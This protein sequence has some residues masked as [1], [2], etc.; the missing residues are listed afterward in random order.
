MDADAIDIDDFAGSSPTDDA[1]SSALPADAE[2]LLDNIFDV[3][4][5]GAGVSGYWVALIAFAVVIAIVAV[6][7]MIASGTREKAALVE[8]TTLDPVLLGGNY[9]TFSY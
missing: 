1:W 9:P 4:S 3:A 6:V 2:D 5:D 8:M 7:L